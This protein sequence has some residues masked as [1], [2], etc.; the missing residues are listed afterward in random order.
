M[1]IALD[2][3]T[4]PL[5]TKSLLQRARSFSSYFEK[6][7]SKSELEEAYTAIYNLVDVDHKEHFIFTSGG[8]EA[9][10][11]VVFAAYIDI[12]R[13]NGK[14]HFIT[15]KAD[16][17]STILAMSRLQEVGCSFHMAPLTIQGQ[18][19][20]QSI[21]ETLT[22]R[23]A[24][25]SLSYANALTGVIQPI[26]E[27]ASICKERGVLFH[28]DFSQALGKKKVSF[29]DC[30]A[31]ILTFHGQH[32]GAPAGTGGLFFREDLNLSPLIL[33]GNEQGGM[34]GGS[35][36][37]PLFF[38]LALAAKEANECTE[39]VCMELAR[40]RY[41]F[42]RRIKE[43]IPESVILFED[44]E[45][46]PH[47]SCIEF[48]EV[49]SEAFLFYL[50]RKGLQASIGGG[51]YQQIHHLLKSCGRVSHSALSFSLSCETT[52]EEI[53]KALDILVESYSRLKKYSIVD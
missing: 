51:D 46:L 22:P 47:I 42:E 16:E 25:L 10:N 12:T 52:E 48:P 34:R 5:P 17:A 37:L 6:E 41:Y 4:H 2:H 15:S 35:F 40:L 28:V 26:E 23:T 20:P 11:H 30:G 31:D 9:V 39:S 38:S 1:K 18:V 53:N 36:S 3:A 14:N 43:V 33:G 24:L 8:S 13:K 44:A 32:L 49:S 27:I 45:R 21:C 19:T 7:P 29:K 50:H